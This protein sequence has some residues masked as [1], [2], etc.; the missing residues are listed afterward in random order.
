VSSSG[1]GAGIP[2]PDLLPPAPKCRRVASAAAAATAEAAAPQVAAA[3]VVAP[4]L[5]V[6]VLGVVLARTPTVVSGVVLG[7]VGRADHCQT[8]ASAVC[9]TLPAI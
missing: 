3:Q 6:I 7:V 4:S 8:A 5:G 2:A 9:A 1:S